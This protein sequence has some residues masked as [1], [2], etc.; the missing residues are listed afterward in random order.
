MRR[1]TAAERALA[2]ADPRMSDL[3]GRVE[4]IRPP[5]L[6]DRFG[7]LVRGIAG[8]Q[9]S[10]AAAWAIFGRLQ[11]RGLTTA[12]AV[13]AASEE[14]MR[15]AG[16]SRAKV[17]YLKDLAERVVDGRLDLDGMD[18]LP[19]E[20]VMRELTAVK[21]VGEWTAD[22][23]L[24]FALHRPDVLAVGDLGIRHAGGWLLGLDRPATEAELRE[25]GEKW[26][27][28]RSLATLYLFTALRDGLVHLPPQPR[29]QRRQVQIPAEAGDGSSTAR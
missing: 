7:S 28:H 13:A 18:G 17:C 23:F 6:G 19:D 8:Q 27:P 12:R 11:E 26:R 10:N 16:M 22:M 3:I 20:E 9:L 15:S 29:R 4:P 1:L 2:A 5:D 25:A 21:G 14:E 24:I